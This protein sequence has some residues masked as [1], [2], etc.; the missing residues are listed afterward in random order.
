MREDFLADLRKGTKVLVAAA[1]S[2]ISHE[3]WYQERRRNAA[4]GKAWNDAMI[5]GAQ[6]RLGRLETEA[7][8]RGVDGYLVVT[9]VAGQPVKAVRHY[10]GRL[11]ELMIRAEAARA[12][13]DS[14]RQRIDQEHSGM[15]GVRQGVLV[16]PGQMVPES[17]DQLAHHFAAIGPPPVP[18]EGEMA[19]LDL[20]ALEDIETEE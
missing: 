2:G 14:Y 12:G 13:D 4:F 1:A 7:V 20:R 19:D 18:Y 11:L 16:V 8:R 6:Q 3:R 9:T 10:D 15:I 5:I 17:W